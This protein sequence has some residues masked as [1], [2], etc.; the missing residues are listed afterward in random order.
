MHLINNKFEN[1]I[2]LLATNFICSTKNTLNGACI[3]GYGIF[4]NHR[5]TNGIGID[6]KI[7]NGTC[8]N[9]TIDLTIF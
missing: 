2:N 6:R 5:I 3:L 9:D 1:L 8:T 4:T 7:G